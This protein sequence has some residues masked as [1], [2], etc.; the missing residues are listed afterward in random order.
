MPV[1]VLDIPTQLSNCIVN[2]A[3]VMAE[4]GLPAMPIAPTSDQE[5]Y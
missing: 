1:K 5:R 2:A 3:E 4:S